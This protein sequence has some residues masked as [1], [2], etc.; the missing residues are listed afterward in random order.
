[1]LRFRTAPIAAL[2]LA[3][4]ASP[5]NAAIY[6]YVDADG[7]VTFT[8]K[9][10]P[11]AI[12]IAE[13]VAHSPVTISS[14][15]RRSKT[16][17]NTSPANFPK[18]DAA[19]QHMRDDIR[20]TLLEEERGKEQKNLATARATQTNSAKHTP[21]EQEKLADNIRLHEK[22]IELLNKEMARIK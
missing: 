8:D 3:V 9:N 15:A 12:K 21:A 11:G 14:P 7:N 19:T 22:N 16:S 17:N 6:K 13:D 5:G 20:R 10:R 1:M 4:L 2:I 18:V